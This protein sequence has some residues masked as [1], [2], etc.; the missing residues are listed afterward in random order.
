MARL[1]NGLTRVP[2]LADGVVPYEEL[3][4]P[5]GRMTGVEL[6][7]RRERFSGTDAMAYSIM[8]KVCAWVERSMR[9]LMLGEGDRLSSMKFL[10]AAEKAGYEIHLVHL[11]A[12]QSV[13]DERCEARGSRQSRHWRIGRVTMAVRLAAHAEAAGHTVHTLDAERPLDELVREMREQM[14]F[15]LELGNAD[16]PVAT[17]H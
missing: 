14:P 10:T 4:A 1:T 5:D 17:R 3:L 16:D 6:G 13:L 11:S 9:E 7:K 15:L 2:Q 12:R 8:P